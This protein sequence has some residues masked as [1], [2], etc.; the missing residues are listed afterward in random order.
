MNKQF[1]FLLFFLLNLCF[2]TAISIGTYPL[3][4]RTIVFQPGLE[5]TFTF[6]IFGASN[7]E[8]IFSPGI[9]E[10]YITL[11]DPNPD[12]GRRE[13]TVNIK[14][15]DEIPV[16]TGRHT[17]YVGALD[18]SGGDGSGMVAR[19]AVKTGI[20]VLVLS[21]DQDLKGSFFVEDVNLG[22]DSNYSLE[23][24]SWSYQDID[25]VVNFQFFDSLGNS[26]LSFDDEVFISATEATV[27]RDD[28]ETSSW[29]PGNYYSK[30]I[31]NF[32]KTLEF[33]DEFIIGELGFNLLSTNSSLFAGEVGK[34]SFNLKSS[35][36]S[37][38]NGLYGVL[39]LNNKEFR[40]A[41]FDFVPKE[42]INLEIFVDLEDFEPGIYPSTLKI[43]QDELISE[44]NFEMEISQPPFT[45]FPTDIG[46]VSVI[47]VLLI[48]IIINLRKPNVESFIKESKKKGLSKK[49]VKK[50]LI[51]KGLYE[52][53]K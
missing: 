28:L 48:L 25:A 52:V 17:V 27:L 11:E 46:L 50:E 4:D 2:A 5:R 14:F 18:I 31:V 35:W 8:A 41:N 37:E 45:D 38:M 30:A 20:V 43:Y 9:F 47:I 10:D 19:T 44:F 15:P 34:V 21:Q 23:L 39:S 26:V 3:E 16:G 53:K 49:Q 12:G 42:D 22:E 24:T 13:L 1:L 40:S 32:D 51:K 36:T 33:A 29:D 7:I 6:E